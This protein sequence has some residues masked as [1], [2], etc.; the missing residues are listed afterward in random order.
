MLT[1]R[2]FEHQQ[3]NLL[4]ARGSSIH[5]AICINCLLA[6]AAEQYLGDTKALLLRANLMKY[7][8]AQ[9]QGGHG[10]PG[11]GGATRGSGGGHHA[12]TAFLGSIG[13]L[14]GFVDAAPDA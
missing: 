14:G 11:G 8:F 7:D 9:K 6:F 3:L 5:M 2:A 1:M 13:G 4:I 10:R 12:S